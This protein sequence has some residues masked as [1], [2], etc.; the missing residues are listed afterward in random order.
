[1]WMT[2]LLLTAV[3]LGMA[4]HAQETGAPTAPVSLHVRLAPMHDIYVRPA[5]YT[6]TVEAPANLEIN[7]PE[8]LPQSITQLSSPRSSEADTEGAP[9]PE[10]PIEV[11]AGLQVVTPLE[12]GR[13]RIVRDYI[14]DP[15]VPGEYLVPPFQIGYDA[16]QI[17][18]APPLV[19]NA[20]EITEDERLNLAQLASV[21]PPAEFVPKRPSQLLLQGVLIGLGILAGLAVAGLL[22]AWRLRVAHAPAPPLPPWEVARQRLKALAGRKLTEQGRYEAYYI[23][24]SSILRYYLEDRFALH[25]PEQTTQELLETVAA[26]DTLTTPQQEQLAKFMRHCDRVKFARYKPNAAE[27]EES[28][29]LVSHFV[30]ETVP[31]AE[32]LATEAAA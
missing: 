2:Y 9:G 14:I 10:V 30:E 28:F 32:P 17:V 26:G 6:V 27:M 4:A 22:A 1:M 29:D 11:S 16:A 19:M 15:I 31:V 13:V 21:A 8:I 23:D 7:L 24:L 20:R 3:V 12:E 5:T 18:S 25:A